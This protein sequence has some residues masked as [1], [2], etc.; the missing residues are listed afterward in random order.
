MNAKQQKL[1][2][3]NKIIFNFKSKAAKQKELLIKTQKI[4]QGFVEIADE[5]GPLEKRRRD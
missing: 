1:M 2:M 3:N 4:L 5:T